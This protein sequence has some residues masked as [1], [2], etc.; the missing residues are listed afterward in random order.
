MAVDGAPRRG[1][2]VTPAG[3]LRF[4]PLR[5]FACDASFFSQNIHIPVTCSRTLDFLMGDGGSQ[6]PGLSRLVDGL[7]QKPALGFNSFRFPFLSSFPPTN[8]VFLWLISFW[9]LCAYMIIL[10]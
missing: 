4:E 5:P 8:L 9:I 2:S 3:A 7:P 6:E 1:A 10:L